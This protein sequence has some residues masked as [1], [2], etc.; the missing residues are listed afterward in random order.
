MRLI[1]GHGILDV[2]ASKFYA[3]REEVLHSGHSR[4]LS[5]KFFKSFIGASA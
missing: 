2:Y 4:F 3:L 5:L 1:A